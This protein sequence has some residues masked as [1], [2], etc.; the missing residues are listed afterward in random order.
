MQCLKPKVFE[1]EHKLPFARVNTQNIQFRPWLDEQDPENVLFT[2]IHLY[3]GD[4]NGFYPGT[5]SSEGTI[6]IINFIDNTE[7]D[8]PIYPGGILNI[9]LFPRFAGSSKWRRCFT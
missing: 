5:G 2:S 8:N 4:S 3:D 6:I 9:P 1:L 7:K